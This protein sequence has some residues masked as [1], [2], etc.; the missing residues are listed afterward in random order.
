M[1][2]VQFIDPPYNLTFDVETG[3]VIKTDQNKGRARRLKN[4]ALTC[5]SL[6]A[7]A[8]P[9][10]FHNVN[11]NL[12]KAARVRK[13][14]EG[15]KSILLARV[16]SRQWTKQLVITNTAS[17]ERAVA[18]GAQCQIL[19][20][21][22][23]LLMEGLE[24]ISFVGLSFPSWAYEH[25]NILPHLKYLALDHCTTTGLVEFGDKELPLTHF[26]LDETTGLGSL[27]YRT[28][29]VEA[30][31]LELSNT[32]VPSLLQPS[33]AISLPVL[34][35]LTILGSDDESLPFILHLLQACPALEFLDIDTED[36]RAFQEIGNESLANISLKLSSL[37]L[38]WNA[39]EVLLPNRPV[40]YLTTE[41]PT[42][43]MTLHH[44]EIMSSGSVPVSQ[45]DLALD[46]CDRETFQTMGAVLPSLLGLVIRWQLDLDWVRCLHQLNALE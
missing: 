43:R 19:A 37:A 38:P 17:T 2:V 20:G 10:L 39:L 40:R 9:S 11:V 26:Y 30:L 33:K 42:S 7:L 5:K 28:T 41:I 13:R 31:T 27:L 34:K 21:E 4:L 3:E 46:F 22:M 8:Q 29:S 1:G 23:F 15:L 16:E 18:K 36:A 35:Q 24:C 25:L 14:I 44:A 45:L 6:R 12:Q 32:I